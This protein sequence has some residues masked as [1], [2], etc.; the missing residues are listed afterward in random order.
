MGGGAPDRAEVG[1]GLLAML[2]AALLLTGVPAP[3]YAAAPDTGWS[4]S[5]PGE[6]E[7]HSDGTGSAPQFSYTLPDAGLSTPQT[8]TFSVGAASTGE[9]RLPWGWDGFHAFFQV[10]ARLVGFVEHAGSVTET[11]LLDEGPADCCTEPSGGFRYAGDWRPTVQAGDTYGF[12]VTGQNNDSDNRLSGTFTVGTAP[13]TDPSVATDNTGWPNALL[14]GDEAR[15]RA[16][17]PPRGRRAGTGSPSARRDR[18][19]RP[20]RPG[21]RPRP[22]AVPRHRSGVHPAPAPADL[23]RSARSSPPTPTA[24]RSTRPSIY[25]P[26]IYSPSI[27]SP[28]IYSPSIYS[29]SIYSPR[30]TRRRSTAR[31]STRRRSTARRST[32]RRSTRRRSTA[33]TQAFPD[34]VLQRPD[35]QPARR[36]GRAP[37][38]AGRVACGPRRGTTPAPSTCGCRARRDAPARAALAWSSRRHLRGRPLQ[39]L[40]VDADA[41]PR[42]TPAP[43]VRDGRPHRLLAAAAAHRLRPPLAPARAA[44]PARRPVVDARDQPRGCALN[45]A[46]RRRA[47]LRVREEPRRRGA[48]RDSSPPHAAVTGPGRTSSS[49]ATTASS[50][51]SATPTPP[52]SGRSRSTCRRCRRRPASRGQP[53]Q[54]PGPRPGRLRRHCSTCRSRA[55]RPGARPRGGPAGRDA[56]RDRRRRS[57]AFLALPGGVLPAPRS[58]LVTGYDFLADAA[59]AV[60][61]SFAR[62]PRPGR[63]RQAR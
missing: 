19:G 39:D 22:A 27:Y 9:V 45:A 1:A 61:A 8:W 53:A 50:R 12:L 57:T 34:R 55:R 35:P 47:V 63:P 18:A 23:T 13:Y 43:R 52:A 24:R 25:S 2:C 41:P 4:A 5:G 58:A 49:P 28:S 7:L 48:A 10:R 29:P 6:V 11:V 38:S 44:R 42:R 46:G 14:L 31:R 21:R 32:A 33:R 3:G 15:S 40:A 59:D 56:G 16:R 62:R 20:H 54:Q 17:S 60:H 37:G 26:S 30:S 36:V 51:S